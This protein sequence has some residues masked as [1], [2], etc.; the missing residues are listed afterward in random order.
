MNSQRTERGLQVTEGRADGEGIKY[1]VNAFLLS[2]LTF[3][4]SGVPNTT[5]N[6]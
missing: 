5:T 2:K 6:Q 3:F 1:Y 4:R